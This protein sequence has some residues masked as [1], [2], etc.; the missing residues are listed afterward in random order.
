MCF[1]ILQAEDQKKLLFEANERATSSLIEMKRRVQGAN[2]DF[3]WLT[4]Q[5]STVQYLVLHRMGFVSH[6]L[7]LRMVASVWLVHYKDS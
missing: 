2:Y 3:M 5:D 1:F 4:T 6:E 7:I